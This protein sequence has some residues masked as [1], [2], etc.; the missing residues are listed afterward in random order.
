MTRL[1]IA[2][3]SVLCGIIAVLLAKSLLVLALGVGA[4]LCG[5]ASVTLVVFDFVRKD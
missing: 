4:L 2:M 3:S 5:V 1:L